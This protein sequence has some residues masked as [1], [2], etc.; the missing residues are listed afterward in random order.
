MR[1]A[2]RVIALI[3]AGLCLLVS[4]VSADTLQEKTFAYTGARWPSPNT[5][6]ATFWEAPTL[7]AGESRT[8]GVLT[9]ENASE[10]SATITLTEFSLP[11]DNEQQM[12]YLNQLHLQI[13]DGDTLLYNGAYSHLLDGDKPVLQVT[14]EPGA[15]K[16]YTVNTSCPF[17]VSGVPKET[18]VVSWTFDTQAPVVVESSATDWMPSGQTLALIGCI[19]GAVVFFVLFLLLLVKFIRSKEA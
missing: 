6:V 17:T 8:G 2:A 7:A 18:P 9:L 19:A 13:A 5:N 14:L 1:R 12:A 15:S 4:G 11:Y 3:V 10:Q 16:T